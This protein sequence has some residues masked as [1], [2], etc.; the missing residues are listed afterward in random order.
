MAFIRTIE[1]AQ[2]SGQLA[3]LYQRYA[4]PD[5]SVDNVLKVHSVNPSAL[6]AHLQ[7]YIQAMHSASPLSRAEREMVAV[8]V[9]RL[10]NCH[11]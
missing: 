7:L 10:N 9:S 11:Y 6:T 1:P 2:A 5:G 4:N 8:A 3:E